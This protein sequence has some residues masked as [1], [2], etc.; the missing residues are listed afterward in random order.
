MLRS[1]YLLRFVEGSKN[2]WL[3]TYSIKLSCEELGTQ[4]EVPADAEGHLKPAVIFDVISGV[5]GTGVCNPSLGKF[6]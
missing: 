2:S 4:F 5:I 1:L 6:S 3:I